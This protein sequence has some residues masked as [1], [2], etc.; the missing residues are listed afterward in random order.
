MKVLALSRYAVKGLG[1]DYLDSI[2]LDSPGAAF[3]EDRRYAL[4]KTKNRAKFDP[5]VSEWIFKQNFLCAFTYGEILNHFVTK[6][7]DETKELTVWKRNNAGQKSDQLLGPVN[8]STTAGQEKVA[9]FFEEKCG[10]P[11][12]FVT[13]NSS[14]HTHQFGNTDEG[15]NMRGDSR[16]IH[17]VNAATVREVEKKLGVKL[18]AEQFR[19]NI[20][21]DGLEA[22]NDFDAVGKTM[23]VSR[24]DGTTST[25]QFEGLTRCVRCP[26]IGVDPLDPSKPRVDIPKLLAKHYPEHGPYLGIY[27]V[28]TNP[29][30]IQVGDKITFPGEKVSSIPEAPILQNNY[31]WA[32][33]AAGVAFALISMYG[34]KK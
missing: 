15:F 26:G 18:S 11:L 3:P 29:G 5:N 33:A 13:S 16:T 17:I 30:D 19:P 9:S 20:V 4:I 25:L 2:I 14:E 21:V 24:S 34:K 6:Y 8:I 28:V 31:I 1:P 32:A 12:S 23:T 22:W 7:D 27:V 10:E